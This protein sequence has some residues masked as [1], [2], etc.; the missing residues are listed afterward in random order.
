MMKFPPKRKSQLIK[1]LWNL[2][3][4]EVR[5]IGRKTH[6]YKFKHMTRLPNNKKAGCT[7]Q[8]PFIIIP[9]RVDKNQIDYVLKEIGCW[10]FSQE[11]I[12]KACK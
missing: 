6:P 4:V 7:R 1:L 3:F 11:E 2:G 9:H 5:R 10:G 12:E 8:P